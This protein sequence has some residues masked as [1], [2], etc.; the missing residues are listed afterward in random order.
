MTRRLFSVLLL[1][2]A[3]LSIAAQSPV[4]PPTFQVDPG[5]A[6]DSRT[7]GCSARCRRLPWIRAITSGCCTGR[8]RFPQA[9]R[10]NAAP[11]VLEFDTS[12]KLLGELGRPG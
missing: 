8:G 7:T 10:A 9:Q 11:P 4:R 3:T 2:L 6:D 5:L 12:G 1:S